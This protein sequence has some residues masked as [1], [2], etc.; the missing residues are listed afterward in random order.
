VTTEQ[1]EKPGDTPQVSRVVDVNTEPDGMLST[2]VGLANRIEL[3]FGV[4]LHVSGI[5]IS[6]T[7][8]SFGTYLKSV[9]ESVRMMNAPPG[10]ETGAESFA[11]SFDHLYEE[12][13][14]GIAEFSS[15]ASG[16]EDDLPSGQPWDPYIHLRD[17]VVWAPGA[18]PTLPKTLWRG[19]LSHVSAWSIGTF[20]S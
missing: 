9:A 20:G 1:I 13:Q 11:A 18:Q 5:I 4:T 10:H 16:G 2:F 8:I 12:Y 3:E 15:R 14:A 6:G 17:A 19:R 7:L